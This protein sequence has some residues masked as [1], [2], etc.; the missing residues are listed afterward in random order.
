MAIRVGTAS[1]THPTLLRSGGCYPPRSATPEDRLRFYVSRFPVVEE[2]DT[3]YAVP[4]LAQAGLR[5][6]STPNN[7]VF[8]VKAFRG[9]TLHITPLKRRRGRALRNH[10]SRRR[11]DVADHG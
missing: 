11:S 9:F 1:W 6:A 10:H 7:F 3:L 4:A 2:D 8:N 5:L